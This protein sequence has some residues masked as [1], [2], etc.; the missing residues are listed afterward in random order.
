M[1]N[2][3][4]IVN[5]FTLL[6]LLLVIASIAVIAGFSLP[7]WRNLQ[8]KNDLDIS[9]VTIA[10]TLRRAQILAQAVDTDLGWGVRVQ[11]GSIVLFKGNTYATRD[12]NFDEI[13]TLQSSI[14]PSG[15]SEVDYTKFTGLP[16][17]TGTI[18]LTSEQDS[19]TIIINAKGMASY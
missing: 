13:F 17:T 18:I 10:Q 7:L 19:K 14:A 2:K 16:G 3:L 9:V 11:S 4:R 8:I 5:G 6:E 15:L 1:T 12:T